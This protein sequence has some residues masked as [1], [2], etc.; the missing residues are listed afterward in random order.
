LVYCVVREC[1]LG[2]AEEERRDDSHILSVRTLLQHTCMM[3]IPRKEN[4][5]DELRLLDIY[6]LVWILQ[7][8]TLA[9]LNMAQLIE[10]ARGVAA[11]VPPRYVPDRVPAPTTWPKSHLKWIPYG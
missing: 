9:S 8:L 7:H 1:A 10:E 6:I 4:T 2:G 3:M 11:E 5:C